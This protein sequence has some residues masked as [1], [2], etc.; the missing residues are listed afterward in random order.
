MKYRLKGQFSTNPD[1]ALEQI[2]YDRGVKDFK[3]FMNPSPDCELNPH[4]LEN[5]EAAADKLLYHLRR[6]SKIL[7][8]VD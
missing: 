4:N 5:I 3:N 7:F 2:L 6:K 8:V 1:K